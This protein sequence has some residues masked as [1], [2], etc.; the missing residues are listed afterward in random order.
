MKQKPKKRPGL[1]LLARYVRGDLNNMDKWSR[2]IEQDPDSRATAGLL[3][4]LDRYLESCAVARIVPASR[5]LADRIYAAFRA[6]RGRKGQRVARLY[7]D[8]QSLP[9]PAGIRPSL[10]S[11][12]RLKY[13]VDSCSLELT[14]TPVFPG[15]FE[16]TGR[17]ED[18]GS[19]PGRRVRLTGRRSYR[20]TID[21]F[22]FFSFAAVNPGTYQLSFDTEGRETVIPS[23]V[24]R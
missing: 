24:L 2:L 15:R 11:E 13:M 21:R 9:L 18:A 17:I 6:G 20:G 7:F 22:G 23:L 16:L 1:P 19:K 3:R 4:I 5:Q 8:S 14:V 10:L 12:R